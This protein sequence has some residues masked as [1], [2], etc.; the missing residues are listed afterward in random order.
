MTPDPGVREVSGPDEARWTIPAPTGL[1]DVFRP[2]GVYLGTVKLPHDLR[3]A[4]IGPD[5]VLGMARDDLDVEYVRMYGL[6]RGLG[7]PV[8]R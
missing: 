4:E 5:Y 2:D 3:I 8:A 6:D 1:H 7:G